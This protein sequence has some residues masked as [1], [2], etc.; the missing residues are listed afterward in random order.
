MTEVKS[1]LS[2]VPFASM[3]QVLGRAQGALVSRDISLFEKDITAIYH[4]SRVQDM[5]RTAV[6][7]HETQLG[8]GLADT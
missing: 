7:H 3:H 6:K 4:I 2:K 1:I 5:V 8:R